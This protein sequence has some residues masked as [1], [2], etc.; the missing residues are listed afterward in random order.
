[1]FALARILDWSR[2]HLVADARR[3]NDIATILRR[4]PIK[5]FP[6]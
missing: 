2:E 4:D 6:A 5:S 1:M 3:L